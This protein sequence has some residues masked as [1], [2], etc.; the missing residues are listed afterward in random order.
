MDETDDD[1]FMTPHPASPAGC[2]MCEF[3][4]AR[5]TFYK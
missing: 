3:K 4:A 2:S 1:Y 5:D